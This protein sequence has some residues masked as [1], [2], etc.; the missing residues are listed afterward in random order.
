MEGLGFLWAGPQALRYAVDMQTREGFRL[1]VIILTLNQRE[2]TLRLLASLLPQLEGDSRVL[3]WDNGSSDDT[4]EAVTNAFPGVTLQRS[5]C[6]L[7]VAAGRNAAA[8]LAISSWNPRYLLFLDNDLV[9]RE[10]FVSTLRAT[11]DAEMEVGQVQ[12]KLL[13]LGEPGRINDGGGSRIVFWLG[14]TD[15]VGFKELDRGQC[16]QLAPCVSCGGAMMVRRQLFEQLDGFDEVFSP[17]G[18][19]DIDFSLRLQ[20]LGYQA[21]YNPAA[22][23]LHAANH[24][25]GKGDV[26]GD[27][28]RSRVTHWLKFLRRH[29][30][31]SQRAA[32]YL[33]GAPLIGLRMVFR[34]LARGNPRAIL[35]SLKGIV[36]HLGAS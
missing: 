22:V 29:A 10:G 15:P 36:R 35:G 11:L 9:L 30:T 20:A 2:E 13:Y 24:T 19:E 14:K 16:E 12:G 27:Y 18:P 25:W 7:G 31:P 23:A 34:E 28:A 33:A 5:H 4:G 6:N 8:R 32:F 17:Y 21:I 26:S 1:A 3:V